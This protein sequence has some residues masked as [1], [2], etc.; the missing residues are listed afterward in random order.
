MKYRDVNKNTSK[1][2]EK[3]KRLRKNMMV[4]L[5]FVGVLAVVLPQQAV[6]AGTASDTDINN[7]A[8]INYQISGVAQTLIESSPTGNSTPGAGNGT[9]TTFKV[10]NKVDLV[11]VT[12]D[13]AAV[14]V[15]PGSLYANGIYN[16]LE[17]RVQNDGNTTQDYTL[18]AIAVTTGGAAKFAGNDA[19]DMDPP[20]RIY[21]NSVQDVDGTYDATDTAVFIDELAA[22]SYV[23]VFVVLDAPLTAIDGQ[24]A[25]YH[26]VATTHDGGAAGQG[27]LTVESAGAWVPGTVQVVFADGTGTA[28][29][30]GDRD[31]EFSDQDDYEVDTADLTI[32]K[33]SDVL[34]DGFNVSPNAKAIPGAIIEYTITIANDA[35]AGATATSIAVSDSLNT[36]ITNGT[37]AFVTDSYGAGTGIE[38]TAP[39]LYGGA[40]TALTNVADGDE[41]D[42]TANVVTVTG[43]SLA[44]GEQATVKF[45]VIVQ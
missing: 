10:D 5:L 16:V 22:D 29:T 45:R 9:D 30:D 18:S 14:S 36:E 17:F 6:A 43:I 12:Q 24:I 44:A 33:T 39:N 38:V 13:V 8:T 35:G 3:M 27:A 2:G 25:S 19:F 28:G 15:T 32:D 20:V 23:D 42:F 26:L 31:G 11:V 37:L 34:T 21:V 4:C 7:R 41:G 1:G 40:A